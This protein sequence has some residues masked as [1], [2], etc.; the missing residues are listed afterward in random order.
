M[1][2]LGTVTTRHYLD[3]VAGEP[4]TLVVPVTGVA[5][6]G[7]VQAA[8][9]AEGTPD[10]LD[11][12]GVHQVIT[13]SVQAGHAGILTDTGATGDGA[14][15]ALLTF[16]FTGAQTLALV[17]AGMDYSVRVW[18][19]ATAY[20]TVQQGRVASAVPASSLT[21][22]IGGGAP[23]P[24]VVMSGVLAPAAP[25][26]QNGT[27][28]QMAVT[29]YSGLAGT[30]SVVDDSESWGSASPLVVSIDALTG[31]ATGAADAGTAVL[32]ATAA[33]NGVTASTTATAAAAAAS[34]YSPEFFWS[35]EDRGS[36]RIHPAGIGFFEGQYGG[37]APGPSL[38][39]NHL[40]EVF[41]LGAS[42]ATPTTGVALTPGGSIQTLVALAGIT[43]LPA[44]AYLTTGLS[45]WQRVQWTDYA[46]AQGRGPATWQ[47]GTPSGSAGVGV[48]NDRDNARHVLKAIVMIRD[49]SQIGTT[50]R[51]DV[52]KVGTA[53]DYFAGAGPVVTFTAVDTPVYVFASFLPGVTVAE[54]ADFRAMIFGDAS[55]ERP[56][57]FYLKSL[58][59][60]T[61]VTGNYDREGQ[62][63]NSLRLHEEHG[64]ANSWAVR[65]MWRASDDPALFGG[66][67]KAA[68]AR[69]QPQLLAQ[70][71]AFRAITTYQKVT[72]PINGGLTM[73]G[74]AVTVESKYY[75][76]DPTAVLRAA[77]W[78]WLSIRVAPD[79][80]MPA[81]AVFEGTVTGGGQ[82]IPWIGMTGDAE[83]LREPDGTRTYRCRISV[84]VGI[85]LEA[86]KN[87]LWVPSIR[88]TVAGTWDV[89]RCSMAMEQYN[90]TR[91]LGID[92][93]RY[94]LAA[95][96]VAFPEAGWTW[97]PIPVASVMSREQGAAFYRTRLF[98]DPFDLR[99]HD[100]AASGV[101]YDLEQSG[102]LGSPDLGL[103]A[104]WYPQGTRTRFNWTF[105]TLN[106]QNGL[107]YPQGGY[108]AGDST[109]C[110]FN[111]NAA[112][113]WPAWTD[114][115]FGVRWGKNPD[116]TA[117]L[118]S[119]TGFYLRVGPA[120]PGAWY[121]NGDPMFGGT[122]VAA[123]DPTIA[124]HDPTW[125]LTGSTYPGSDRDVTGQMPGFLRGL[126]KGLTPGDSEAAVLA[127]WVAEM[128]APA[129][130]V[131]VVPAKRVPTTMTLDSGPFALGYKGVRRLRATVLDQFGRAIPQHDAAP[132]AWSSSNA[133][134]ATVNARGVVS[135]VSAGSATITA[136]SGGVPVNVVATMTARVVTTPEDWAIEDVGGIAYV[137][138]LYKPL[139]LQTV[140]AGKLSAWAPFRSFDLVNA[141]AMVQA[142]DAIRPL[143]DG[144]GNITFNGIDQILESA[145]WA[146]G[147]NTGVDG[148][149][150]YLDFAVLVVG[151][152]DPAT[153][154][155][156]TLLSIGNRQPSLKQSATGKYAGAYGFSDAVSTVS[157]V[158]GV[159]RALLIEKVQP[160]GYANSRITILGATAAA[161]VSATSADTSSPG[162]SDA[163]K[164]GMRFA[165]NFNPAIGGVRGVA[166]VRKSASAADRRALATLAQAWGAT[167]L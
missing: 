155:D 89:T 35:M 13:A 95:T 40:V 70:A 81:D 54:T 79:S 23:A 139:A 100:L 60:E 102:P 19:S 156:G 163:I 49:A 124:G 129:S 146:A 138:A 123:I 77:N 8:F 135:W 56:T 141:P 41:A 104:S 99:V 2:A 152:L 111:L 20:Q 72:V 74:A 62:F 125:Q 87:K 98:L 150:L 93:S 92:H 118:R 119:I 12:T 154:A 69:P 94:P 131:G 3:L 106:G 164:L 133:A 9:G 29:W 112:G 120:D 26:I 88:S 126:M 71:N 75:I 101:K 107:P 147:F 114:V 80:P 31:L 115:D 21:G 22:L 149:G 33:S 160:E 17:G 97:H 91:V 36:P 134:V 96:D 109:G 130:A 14:G 161:D 32:T 113:N 153:A 85:A 110:S 143:I 18:S 39:A 63:Q 73:E 103:S 105:S 66:A 25:T 145:A 132:V 86:N 37:L 140:A 162:A 167:L 128:G 51:F 6:A 59:V 28:Q 142:T 157:P 121:R 159:Y 90:E 67:T 158:I 53:I 42:I 58:S 47:N 76:D 64:L 52:R 151:Y 4:W 45:E 55:H 82:T 30:G 34:G 50:I 48:D 117:N 24:V 5:A 166:V 15:T 38:R 43:G 65:N 57:D 84:N 16:V 27:T 116:G 83:P 11:L 68:S 148:A 1:A 136:T 7:L 46:T 165:G 44:H 127:K 78:L 122:S 144:S 108:T 61:D 137:S 10:P